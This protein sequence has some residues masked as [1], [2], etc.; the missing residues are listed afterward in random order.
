MPDDRSRGLDWL[1]LEW[2]HCRYLL[3][4]C[5]S[6][7]RLRDGRKVDELSPSAF[8][9]GDCLWDDGPDCSDSLF[10]F[11]SPIFFRP[12]GA[13]SDGRRWPGA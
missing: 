10:L 5:L 2:L 6:C 1:D 11:C 3:S 9:I 13:R 7:F 8:Q 12:I 4:V